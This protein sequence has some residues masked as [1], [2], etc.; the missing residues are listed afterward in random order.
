MQTENTV[1]LLALP[2]FVAL[3]SVT[4]AALSLFLS[5]RERVAPMRTALYT[6]QVEVLSQLGV[7]V[8][9]IAAPVV[10]AMNNPSRW[11]RL[12]IEQRR[13]EVNAALDKSLEL[14]ALVLTHNAVIPTSIL[15]NIDQLLPMLLTGYVNALTKTAE[16]AATDYRALG[17]A[18]F[19]I[20]TAIR[21]TLGT[22]RLHKTGL[23]LLGVGQRRWDREATIP[24]HMSATDLDDF[25]DLV[26][27]ALPIESVLPVSA[28]EAAEEH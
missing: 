17:D 23:R 28:D 9:A 12:S 26:E 21:T 4:V 1:L 16:E 13:Q 6:R 15:E 2:Q 7:L 14:Q 20:R 25:Y 3:A 11:G 24:R 18:L 10:T 27:S 8:F 19:A 22:D 5:Y